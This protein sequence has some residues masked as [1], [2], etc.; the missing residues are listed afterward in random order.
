M[1]SFSLVWIS[2]RGSTEGSWIGVSTLSEYVDLVSIV[3][4]VV[5]QHFCRDGVER[6]WEVVD[7][8]TG[9]RVDAFQ[10]DRVKWF[11]KEEI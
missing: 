8:D 11:S 10:T 7:G 2:V 3:P 1:N 4:E 6:M 9:G 5:G